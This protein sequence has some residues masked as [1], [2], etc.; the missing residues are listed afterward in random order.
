MHSILAYQSS[1]INKTHI[2]TLITISKQRIHKSKSVPSVDTVIRDDCVIGH[3]KKKENILDYLL[4]K[5]KKPFLSM[6]DTIVCS[7]KQAAHLKK[8]EKEK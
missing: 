4:S 6:Q 8:K 2:Y 3:K 5:E 7:G 1:F